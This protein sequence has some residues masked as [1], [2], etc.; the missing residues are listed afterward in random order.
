M[1]APELI[2]ELQ[3]LIDEKGDKEIYIEV[4][5][6]ERTEY[7]FDIEVKPETDYI[8]IKDVNV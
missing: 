4:D 2:K 7:A 6:I 1:K 8:C 3:K 5:G